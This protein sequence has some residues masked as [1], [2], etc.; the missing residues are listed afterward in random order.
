MRKT[1]QWMIAATLLVCGTCSLYAQTEGNT[2][3]A[4][5]KV[6]IDNVKGTLTQEEPVEGTIT[7]SYSDEATTALPAYVSTLPA[8]VPPR[9]TMPPASPSVGA[10]APSPAS[11]AG[12]DARVPIGTERPSRQRDQGVPLRRHPRTRH[13]PAPHGAVT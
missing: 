12:E 10:R 5:P 8:R 3:R 11:V 1:I 4:L 7:I 2:V 9:P 13:E 6:S